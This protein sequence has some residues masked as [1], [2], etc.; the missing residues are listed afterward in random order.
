MLPALPE[1]RLAFA[2]DKDIGDYPLKWIMTQSA[3]PLPHQTL[4]ECIF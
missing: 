4:L 2:T 3:K 1:A